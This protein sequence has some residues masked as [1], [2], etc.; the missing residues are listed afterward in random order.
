MKSHDHADKNPT[1]CVRR[2]LLLVVLLV[3]AAALAVPAVAFAGSPGLDQDFEYR[4]DN[5]PPEIR[6]ALHGHLSLALSRLRNRKDEFERTAAINSYVFQRLRLGTSYADGGPS[7]LWIGR[8]SCTEAAVS[9]KEL[10]YLAGI[11]SHHAVLLGV[12]MMGNHSMVQ[13]YF[14][15]GRVGLFDPTYGTFWRSRRGTPLSIEKLTAAPELSTRTRYRSRHRKRQ[16]KGDPIVPI[17]SSEAGYKRT[18]DDWE[19]SPQRRRISSWSL[20]FRKQKNYGVAYRGER[21]TLEIPL[22]PGRRYGRSTG[23]GTKTPWYPLVRR[24]DGAGDYLPWPHVVGRRDG[25]EV[26]QSYKLSGLQ[27]GRP[28]TLN[29]WIAVAESAGRVEVRS[30]DSNQLLATQLLGPFERPEAGV[31]AHLLSV[32]LPPSKK[33]TL[34]LKLSANSSLT[35]Q[36]IELGRSSS[37]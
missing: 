35:I 25:F 34:D 33:S 4:V 5:Y 10:L 1:G 22:R 18:S 32:E 12:P 23:D 31:T 29:I 17:K 36:G 19:R 37:S 8:G 3:A 13:V 11:R 16:V 7:I 26:A 24:T 2:M 21:L 30:G 27:P 28:Y 15:D 20:V 14:K 9:M 6:A